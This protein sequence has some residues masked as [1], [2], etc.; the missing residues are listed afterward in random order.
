[1]APLASS[2]AECAVVELNVT[3]LG[4]GDVVVAFVHGVL[5]RGRSFTGVADALGSECTMLCWDRRGYGSA[6]NTSGVAVGIDTHISD[7]LTVLDGRRAVVVGHSFGGIIAMGVA[8]RAPESVE[9]VVAYESCVAWAPGWDDRAMQG[10]F[11]SEDP[12]ASALR[13]MFGERYEEMSGEERQRRRRDAAVFLAEE[14]SVRDGPPFDLAGVRCPVV[15]G[16]SD[17]AVMP[18]VTDYVGHRLSSIE[19][20]TLPGAGHHAHRADPEG[21][22]ALVRRAIALRRT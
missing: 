14:R 22:A 15:Y 9:A 17:A 11:V 2:T 16:L 10:V 7:V 12:E 5:D 21:F 19:F 20:S 4:S 13:L 18:A 3:E 1:M 8:A 6:A